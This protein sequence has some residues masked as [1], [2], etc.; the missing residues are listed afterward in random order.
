MLFSICE[1]CEKWRWGG[2][3]FGYWGLMKLNLEE[4]RAVVGYYPASSGTVLPTCW[5]KLLDP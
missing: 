5:D 4:N 2:P 3:Q 1:F